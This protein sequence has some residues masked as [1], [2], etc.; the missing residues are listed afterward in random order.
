M[1]MVYAPH[2]RQESRDKG[3]RFSSDQ[4]GRAASITSSRSCSSSGDDEVGDLTS[5]TRLPWSRGELGRQHKA[6]DDP[7]SSDEKHLTVLPHPL[8]LYATSATF[9]LLTPFPTL[10]REIQRAP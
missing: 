7:P 4:R 9:E 2:Q 5:A 8:D 3:E 1:R 10:Y 6:G